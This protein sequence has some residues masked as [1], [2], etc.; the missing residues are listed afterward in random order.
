M[1]VMQAQVV[2]FGPWEYRWRTIDCPCRPDGPWLIYGS[3]KENY[4]CARCGRLMD[5]GPA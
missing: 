1:T 4:C 3:P 2:V 5:S